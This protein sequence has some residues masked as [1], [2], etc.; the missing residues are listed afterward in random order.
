MQLLDLIETQL[1]SNRLPLVGVTLAA[2]PYTNTPVVLTFHWHG[3]VEHTLTP[4]P[5]SPVVRYEAVP[6]SALQVNQRWDKLEDLD[7]SALEVAWELGAWDLSRVEARPFIR[8]G[9]EAQES[10]ECM[11]AFGAAPTALDGQPAMVADI[12]DGEALLMAAGRTGYVQW[13]FRPVHGGLWEGVSQ[14]DTLQP[15]GYRNP[16]C[17]V[18]S[19][20]LADTR[21]LRQPRRTVYQLGKLSRLAS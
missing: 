2:V 13:Q 16:P 4:G 7:N 12:P 18:L 17:P 8:P 3:F 14:D 1:V 20:P 5:N 21:W 6:S 15:G 9:A 10:L 11:T 19:H